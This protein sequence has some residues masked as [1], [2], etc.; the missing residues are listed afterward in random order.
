[1][2][3][4]A[5]TTSNSASIIFLNTNT[6]VQDILY[7]LVFLNALSLQVLLRWLVSTGFPIHI[8]SGLHKH[9]TACQTVLLPLDPGYCSH[10]PKVEKVV[11]A[12][13]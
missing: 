11:S 6:H 9:G 5:A 2:K 10:L 12:Q 4:H 7:S 8:H 13:L 3:G 1:M